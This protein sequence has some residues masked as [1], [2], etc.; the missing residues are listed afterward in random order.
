MEVMILFVC[1]EVSCLIRFTTQVVGH[2]DALV[3]PH[4]QE[5]ANCLA[6]WSV[7]FAMGCCAVSINLFTA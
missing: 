3:T 6:R 7:V 2:A 5:V 1:C 4:L